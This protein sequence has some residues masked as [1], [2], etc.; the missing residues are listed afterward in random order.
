MKADSGYQGIT[1]YRN[2]SEITI[3]KHKILDPIG[4]NIIKFGLTKK[5]EDYNHSLSKIR[6]KVE[7]KI[8]EIKIF[9]ILSYTY[10]NFIKKHDL[11]FNIIAGIVNLK[12][13]FLNLQPQM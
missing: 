11:R 5:E 12:N 10:R 8:G 3:K 1:K 9:K 4:N 13:N 6:I 7:N 2:K